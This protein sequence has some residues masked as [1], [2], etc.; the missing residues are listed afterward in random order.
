MNVRRNLSILLALT[1]PLFAAGAAI[2][3]DLVVDL[4]NPVVRITTG[5]AGTDL[6]LFGAKTGEGDVVVVVRGP[7]ED[8][9][10]RRKERVLGVWVNNDRVAFKGVPSYYW[11]A[12]NVPLEGILPA[13]ELARFQI[14]ND[15]L[16]VE[17]IDDSANPAKVLA[18]RDALIRAKIRQGLYPAEPG[19]LSFVNNVLFRTNIRFPSNVSVGEFAIE[20]Y[21]V[22]DKKIVANHTTLLNVRKFGL[23]A[24]IYNFAHDQGLLHGI[25]AV[26]IACFAG[27]LAN[28][29]FRKG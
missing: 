5:F 8:P 21:L 4:S 29:A 22:H 18:Y 24:T 28:A 11:Y 12:S 1:L 27:W 20:T 7:E 16:V 10:V 14:G 17:A 26:I 25:V 9:V 13:D 2:G 15:D 23:E 19:S 6:L 3:K